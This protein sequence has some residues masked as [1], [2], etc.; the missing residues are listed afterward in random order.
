MI[1]IEP[2][3][4]HTLYQGHKRLRHLGLLA[5]YEHPD[6]SIWA[7]VNHHTKHELLRDTKF[8]KIV[9]SRYA[10]YLFEA[11]KGGFVAISVD[12]NSPKIT[13]FENVLK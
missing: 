2:A 12:A 8:Y 11:I 9:Y 5:I 1:E 7:V 13:E 10:S 4:I 3:A 6:D